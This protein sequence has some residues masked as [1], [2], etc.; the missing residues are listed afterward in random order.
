MRDLSGI[1]DEESLFRTRAPTPEDKADFQAA[2]AAAQALPYA[3]RPRLHFKFDRS[4]TG[5]ELAAAL[6]AS[7]AEKGID[8]ENVL[9]R[10]FSKSRLQDA[11]RNASDR[12][13]SANVGYNGAADREEEWM[14]GLGI[15]SNAQV[16]YASPLGNYLSGGADAPRSQDNAY[17]IYDKGLMY[18]VGDAS[19]GFH[20]FLL[21][22]HRTLI[23]FMSDQGEMG[24]SETKEKPQPQALKI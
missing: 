6:K 15:Y 14:R 22:P 4:L 18:K 12:D 2:K 3:E 7:L 19:N 8:P 20:A 1:F 21:T 9:V 23:G 13:E 16:T 10:F 24:L 11:F 5:A 17:V